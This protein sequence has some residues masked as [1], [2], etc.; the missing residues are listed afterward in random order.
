MQKCTNCGKLFMHEEESSCNEC[1][2]DLRDIEFDE[3]GLI[4]E[5]ELEEDEIEEDELEE[6]EVEED[7]L[8]EDELE[9]DEVEE[10]EAEEDEVEEDEVEED[11]LEEDQ[12]KTIINQKVINK[13]EINYDKDLIYWILVVFT[14]VSS[15]LSFASI[16]FLFT[17]YSVITSIFLG[18]ISLLIWRWYHK[19][20]GD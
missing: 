3:N 10:D 20:Y 14:V 17:K 8:E 1:G 6:D 16:I 9:E 13:I 12:Q 7:E 4:I 19:T 11:E 18:F 15:T 2:S 5:D